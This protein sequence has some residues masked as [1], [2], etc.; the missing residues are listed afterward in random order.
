MQSSKT[1]KNLTDPKFLNISAAVKFCVCIFFMKERTGFMAA[2]SIDPTKHFISLHAN[3]L[4]KK[5]SKVTITTKFL[6][7]KYWA[8]VSSCL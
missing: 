8:N 6:S 4:R 7:V 2:G 3:F 5:F 1:L